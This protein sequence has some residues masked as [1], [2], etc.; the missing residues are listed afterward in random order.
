MAAQRRDPVDAFDLEGFLAVPLEAEGFVVELKLARYLAV[1]FP[2]GDD[3]RTHER[4]DHGEVREVLRGLR[5]VQQGLVLGQASGEGGVFD[6]GQHSHF[7][8]ADGRLP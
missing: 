7:E 2:I 3:I 6:R 8:R 5:Q 1:P 4:Q